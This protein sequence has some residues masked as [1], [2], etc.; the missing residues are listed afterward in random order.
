MGSL[1][2][3]KHLKRVWRQALIVVNEVAVDMH[4]YHLP[5]QQLIADDDMGKELR[6][7]KRSTGSQRLA[8]RAQCMN[9]AP[10]TGVLFSRM[11]PGAR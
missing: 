4:G 9:C 5:P 7:P 2:W 1:D 11:I 3:K 8:I 6:I 10:A